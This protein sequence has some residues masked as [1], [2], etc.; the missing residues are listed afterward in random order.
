MIDLLFYYNIWVLNLP[1]NNFE[2][3][4]VKDTNNQLN[5]Y[6]W[7]KEKTITTKKKSLSIFENK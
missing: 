4:K 6:W 2:T 1:K 5:Y 3:I 7:P